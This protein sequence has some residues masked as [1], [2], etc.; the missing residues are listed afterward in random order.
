MASVK[1]RAVINHGKGS[2]VLV[3][4]ELHYGVP[5]AIP[6][7]LVAG[8]QILMDHAVHCLRG[9]DTVQVVGVGNAD[10][11]V[12]SGGQFPAV[13]PPEGPPGAVVVADGIAALTR[14][15]IPET[16][17]SC[18]PKPSPAAQKMSRE[19]PPGT[20]QNKLLRS[21]NRMHCRLCLSFSTYGVLF[22]HRSRIFIYA[23]RQ[24]SVVPSETVLLI[25]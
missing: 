23:Q 15:I 5:E 6:D 17:T 3:V 8:V 25:N 10:I 24:E 19:F 13:L 22:L 7:Q 21:K 9:A 4:Q 2:V 18:L 16:A 11:A 12:G 20:G 14:Y 1:R